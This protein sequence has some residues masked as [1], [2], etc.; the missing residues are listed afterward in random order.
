MRAWRTD[1]YGE[2]EQL[3]WDEIPDPVAGPQEVIVEVRAAGINFF[4]LLQ[5]RGR[6]QFEPAFPFTPGAEV[7]GTLAETGERV[8]A[9]CGQGGYGERVSVPRSRVFAAPENFSD[10]EA[11]AFL[12]NYHTAWFALQQRARLTAGEWLLVH[13]GASGVGT[14]AIQVARS[15]EARVVATAGSAAKLEHCRRLGAEAAYSYE[16]P[17]WPRHV[18]ELTGGGVNVVFDPVGGEIFDQTSRC[19]AMEGRLVIIGFA[20]GRIPEIAA[21]RLLLRNISAVGAIWGSYIEAHPEYLAHTQTLLAA[22][23]A[24]GLLQPHVGAQYPLRDAP[25]ALRDL[26]Q[27]RVIGKA[28]LVR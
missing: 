25:Q 17:D 2:P 22:L 18:R 7:C 4:D 27:R 12:V 24:D 15:M 1:Q 21:N 11:A 6:Y 20:S 9:F 8:I 16:D 23:A 5:I 3:R 28:V 26:E 19:L 14:A 13:A 10:A